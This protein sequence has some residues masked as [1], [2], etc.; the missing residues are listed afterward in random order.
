MPWPRSAIDTF[1][2]R[3]LM[4]VGASVSKW[5]MSTDVVL[6]V[7]DRRTCRMVVR[8]N[9]AEKAVEV[10]RMPRSLRVQAR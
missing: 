4:A 7:R 5:P 6:M 10:L 9:V 1:E 2:I 3:W 8:M